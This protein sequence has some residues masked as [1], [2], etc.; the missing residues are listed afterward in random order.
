MSR[1]TCMTGWQVSVAQPFLISLYY[2]AKIVSDINELHRNLRSCLK[3]HFTTIKARLTCWLLW[4]WCCLEAREASWQGSGVPSGNTFTWHLQVA[5]ACV[6]LAVA[7]TSPASDSAQSLRR[8]VHV[9]YW[10]LSTKRDPQLTT[11]RIKNYYCPLINQL[12]ITLQDPKLILT[13]LSWCFKLLCCWE[14]ASQTHTYGQ[15]GG[16][17]QLL[18]ASREDYPG[19]WVALDLA[20]E[21]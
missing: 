21:G 6:L 15:S 9:P 14:A 18:R 5:E 13:I 16:R 10:S 11:W 17:L 3:L 12:Y 20:L 7:V 19:L 4:D 1:S 8:K 2:K